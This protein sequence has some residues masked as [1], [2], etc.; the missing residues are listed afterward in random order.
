MGIS[1]PYLPGVA[2]V[3]EWAVAIINLNKRSVGFPS[4]VAVPLWL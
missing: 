4:I 3:R 1:Q 2:P